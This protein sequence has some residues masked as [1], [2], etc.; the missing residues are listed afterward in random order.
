MIK[1]IN[2]PADVLDLMDVRDNCEEALNCSK[3]EWIQFLVKISQSENVTVLVNYNEQEQ[4]NG[5]VVLKANVL[6]PLVSNATIIHVWC[7]EMS[8]DEIIEMADKAKKWARSQGA[9]T[10]RTSCN[11]VSTLKKFGFFETGKIV[12]DMEA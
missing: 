10:V 5:Y 7:S 12:M 6:P 8:D 3:M 1:A 9:E 11:D 2:D 4:I